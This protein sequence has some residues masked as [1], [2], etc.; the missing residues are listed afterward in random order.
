M[1]STQIGM[2]DKQRKPILQAAARQQFTDLE[3][4][5]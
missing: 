1:T 2:S 3:T 4:V 5:V